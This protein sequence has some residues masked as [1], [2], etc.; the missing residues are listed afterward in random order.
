MGLLFISMDINEKTWSRLCEILEPT[1]DDDEYIETI[2][3]ELSNNG[4][5]AEVEKPIDISNI[6]DIQEKDKD[7]MIYEDVGLKVHRRV[8]DRLKKAIK[9]TPTVCNI[10]IRRLIIDKDNINI[11]CNVTYSTQEEK[12]N[13][14]D[15]YS[16]LFEV[17]E[18]FV[19]RADE[20]A[21]G[22]IDAHKSPSDENLWD[23]DGTVYK[24]TDEPYNYWSKGSNTDQPRDMDEWIDFV[25]E[26]KDEEEI[27]KNR[28]EHT[29]HFHPSK[30]SLKNEHEYISNWV[31]INNNVKKRFSIKSY[32]SFKL[33]K[34]H[35]N[36]E[37]SELTF[38]LVM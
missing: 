19:D 21:Y 28:D 32:N 2:R 31:K 18:D 13:I 33:R 29:V 9:N 20:I 11:V 34:I 12:Y 22:S 37:Y 35:F 27:V 15:K 1:I 17:N 16:K 38:S 4:I 23:F 30:F 14:F 24:F 10:D 26:N 3:A 8:K 5:I 6:E 36:R 25:A 7:I